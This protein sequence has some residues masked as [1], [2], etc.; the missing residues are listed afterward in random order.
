MDPNEEAEVRKMCESFRRS[1]EWL[2]AVM[3]GTPE[4]GINPS[5]AD[6]HQL[7]EVVE[8]LGHEEIDEP[9]VRDRLISTLQRQVDNLEM[10]CETR[11]AIID[12]QT[13]VNENQDRANHADHQLVLHSEVLEKSARHY[14]VEQRAI[15]AY[16][17]ERSERAEDWLRL[18]ATLPKEQQDIYRAEAAEWVGKQKTVCTP[19]ER[20]MLEQAPNQ[21]SAERGDPAR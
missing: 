10:I 1:R 13:S 8:A 6:L 11:K 2:V 5:R 14:A 16:V 3:E 7:I 4:H 20:A 15:L 9:D 19:E 18:W 12:L 17:L 21:Q